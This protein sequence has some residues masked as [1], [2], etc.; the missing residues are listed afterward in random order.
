MTEETEELELKQRLSLIES[1]IAE[2]RRTTE[3]W[4]WVFVLWGVAYYV[5]IAWSVLGN[6]ASLAWSVT[7]MAAMIF[8]F[9][10]VAWRAARGRHKSQPATTLGRAVTSVWIAIGIS[11]LVLMP[12]LAIGK[13]SNSNLI[14]AVIGTL[15]GTANGASSMILK[16]KLQFACAIVWWAL[17][18]VACLGTERQSFI[19]LL[20]ALFFCQILFG[21]Y[22]MIREAQGH[23]PG[24]YH[25]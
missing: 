17:A 18:I 6:H 12:V 11:F 24:D 10:I 22:G 21:I 2:G 4:G 8:T 1:M 3:S 19:A 16:W 14:V 9:G 25:A 7:M 20:I 13:L 15:L 5:A 23:R